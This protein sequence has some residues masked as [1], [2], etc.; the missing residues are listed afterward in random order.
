MFK[1]ENVG[2][3]LS[4]LSIPM[5]TITD[6]SKASMKKRTLLLTGRIYSGETHSSWVIHGFIRFLCGK[7]PIAR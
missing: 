4:G 7:S 2:K 1:Y 6:F 5:V 3:T